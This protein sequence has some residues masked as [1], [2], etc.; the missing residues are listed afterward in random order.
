ML[1]R[2]ATKSIL[3]QQNRLTNN[4]KMESQ[5]I[6]DAKGVDESCIN[7]FTHDS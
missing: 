6:E 7:I 1:K 3:N 5:L 2:Q 4:D